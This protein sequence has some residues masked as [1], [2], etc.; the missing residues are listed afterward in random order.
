M[1][2]TEKKFE[3][4]KWL[5]EHDIE[6]TKEFFEK[7]TPYEEEFTRY[8]LK[9]CPFNKTEEDGETSLIMYAN[10]AIVFKCRHETCKEKKWKDFRKYFEPEVSTKKKKKEEK[11]EILK[12]ENLE[13]ELEKRN[14]DIKYN[15]ISNEI[16]IKWPKCVFDNEDK[17]VTLP[18][19]LMSE[20]GD[21]YIHANKDTIYDY[22]QYIARKNRYNPVLEMIQKAKWD[23]ENRLEDIYEILGL[24]EDDRLSR[25]LIIKWMWQGLALLENTREKN[26][27]PQGILVL[28]GPQGIGKTTFLS[29]IAKLSDTCHYFRGGQS[30]D[31]YDKDTRRRCLTTWITELGELDSTFKRSDAGLLKAFITQS[32]DEYRLPYARTDEKVPR[33]TNLCASVNENEFLIDPTG[34]RRYWTIDLE[35]IDIGGIKKFNSLQLWAQIKEEFFEKDKTGFFLTKLEQVE[36]EKRN[37]LF[38]KL[39]PG[40]T[41][42]EDIIDRIKRESNDCEYMT[43]T[44]FMNKHTN[45]Q[46]FKAQQIAK[47]LTKLGYPSGGRQKING[48][49]SRVRLLPVYR[50]NPFN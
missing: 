47:V 41:E 33:R 1:V 14:I 17:F 25:I 32:Y 42:V 35:D 26:V 36:L 21:K 22:L 38:E 2:E 7:H 43:V 8:S 24:K 28:K 9:N 18:T 10:G 29:E 30:I 27:Q 20:L 5:N 37:G 6:Y 4:D 48:V 44:E 23:G 34:N 50:K 16:E 3:L 46:K 40:Q 12:I 39:L 49:T 45:L 19:H 31:G 15:T 11:K 13:L